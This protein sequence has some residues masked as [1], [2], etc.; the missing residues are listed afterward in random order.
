MQI[1][2]THNS[3]TNVTLSVNA[4]AETLTKV[5]SAT[6]KR[7]NT[8]NLK[9][10]GFR[11]GKAPIDLVEKHVDPQLLQT[12]F[13]DNALNFYYNQAVVKEKL[14]VAGEPQVKLQKFVPFTTLEFEV[15]VDILGEVKLPNYKKSAPKKAP[16][17]ITSKEVTEVLSSLQKRLAD[18]KEVS[19]AAKLEDEA[20]I[21][22][23][24]TNEKGEAIAG[25]A[26]K[27]YPLLL[28]SNAFI[29]GFEDAVIGMKP[30]DEKTFTLNFPKDYSVKS[31]Q[32]QKV[33]F[34]VTLKKLSELSN[35]K[36]DDAFAKKAGPFESLSE[37]KK[38]IKRQLKLERQTEIDRQFES[39]LLRDLANKTKVDIPSGVV[40]EQVIRAEQDEKQNLIYRGQTWE[41]H[42][43]A[44]GV[45]E[46]EHRKKNRPE[47]LEQ[48]KIGIM[49]GAI[50]D[51][52]NI[53]VTPE[54]IEIRMQ[55]LKGQYSDPAMQQ[56]LDKPQARQ[57][58]AARIRTEKII[59]RLVEYATKK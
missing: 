45:T 50:G 47:A 52:E 37:L 57:D 6:L 23:K 9:I 3:P 48:L 59:S 36:L 13:I 33:T 27:D 43:K 44:E 54:E 2:L 22:F 42:L 15:T 56:E 29:P 49:L 28:G 41:E 21:D 12:E 17:E 53:E 34:T 40:D 16:A 32:A 46:E 55:L 14:R 8:D 1:K 58:I 20:W 31:L 25:A 4:D 7:F 10:P 39:D 11:G 38:D 26:G 30:G 5:K 18:K 35:P 51:Q 19:R 24:G